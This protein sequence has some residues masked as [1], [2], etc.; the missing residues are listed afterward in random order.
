MTIE[1]L[2][3]DG[4]TFEAHVPDEAVRNTAACLLD[5]DSVSLKEDRDV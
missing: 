1:I 5:D 3:S 2:Y 4:R